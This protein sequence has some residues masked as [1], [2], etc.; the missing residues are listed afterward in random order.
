MI[1]IRSDI[2]KMLSEVRRLANP[3][4]DNSTLS[5]TFEAIITTQFQ[6]TQKAV[7]IQTGSL[8]SSGKLDTD[9]DGNSWKGV[10]S[11]GGISSGIHNPVRY[12][13]H[14]LERGGLHDYMS[15]GIEYERFYGPAISSWMRGE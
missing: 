9:K 12:A 6:L 8:K 2:E 15:E 3:L 10:I 5:D 13:G 11:Y 14:E 4:G 7:H 1:T